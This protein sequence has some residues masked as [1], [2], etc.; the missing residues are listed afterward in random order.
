MI[1]SYFYVKDK[2]GNA[3]VIHYFVNHPEL[4]G[5]IFMELYLTGV[6][7]YIYSIDDCNGREII[8]SSDDLDRLEEYSQKTYKYPYNY[9]ITCWGTSLPQ[10]WNETYRVVRYLK[11]LLEE[12][13]NIYFRA[14]W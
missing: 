14:M 9:N 4:N 10:Q 13:Q 11:S 6:K 12:K 2:E 3:D 8:L 1:S 7:Q 5:Y